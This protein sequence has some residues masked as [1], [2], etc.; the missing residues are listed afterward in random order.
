MSPDAAVTRLARRLRARDLDDL[1]H[2][3]DTPYEL[4]AG[5]L[6]MSRRP[7]FEHQVFLARLV[8][9]VDPAVVQAGGHIVQEPGL[10][11]D[12]EGND[13]V[14]PDL[15]ILLRVPRPARAIPERGNHDGLDQADGS[16]ARGRILCSRIGDEAPA[17]LRGAPEERLMADRRARSSPGPAPPGPD[18][19]RGSDA[20]PGRGVPR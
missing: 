14:S 3:W 12:D 15:A 6:Y 4:I 11:W 13:N 17:S 16:L 8:I 20:F 19:A 18:P 1:P 2:E 5:V 7:S 9:R 10:V